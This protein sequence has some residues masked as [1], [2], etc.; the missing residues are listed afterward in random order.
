MI[1]VVFDTN[2]YRN[3]VKKCGF[4]DVSSEV[5]KIK[6]MEKSKNVTTFISPIVGRE[7]LYHIVDKDD[8]DYSSCIK[9]IKA[10]YEHCGDYA[11][12]NLLAT[13]EIQIA[14]DFFNVENIPAI[15]TSNAI[16]QMLFH[17]SK[18]QSDEIFS[19][20]DTNLKLN[21]DDIISTEELLTKDIYKWIHQIDPTANSWK[22][23]E[24]DNN[25]RKQFLNY[26]DSKNFDIEIASAL[27]CAVYIN[28]IDKDLISKRD[29]YDIQDMIPKFINTYKIPISLQRYFVKQFAFSFFDLT[30]KPCRCNFIWDVYILFAAGQT[31]NNSPIFLV[32]DD[33]AMTIESL[34]INPNTPIMTYDKYIDFLN[35]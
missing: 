28:L 15:E 16:C 22:V 3:L 9:A 11:K 18:D 32:T 7:L 8:K 14:R 27:L 23:F 1:N 35:S 13:P 19:K 20:F 12:Y 2:A 34:K 25:K 26:I 6:E 30:K 17:F 33:K 29:Q 10:M 4:R 5:S 21:K 31:T 24:T